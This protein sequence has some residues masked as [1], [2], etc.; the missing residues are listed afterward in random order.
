MGQTDSNFTKYVR[1]DIRPTVYLHTY[2]SV[3][4]YLSLA[5]LDFQSESSLFVD[6]SLLLLT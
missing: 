6:M 5:S 2:I 3:Y 1:Y 4:H